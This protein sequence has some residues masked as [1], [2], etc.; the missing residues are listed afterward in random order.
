MEGGSQ[1][2]AGSPGIPRARPHYRHFAA[3]LRDYQRAEAGV[4]IG[5]RSRPRKAIFVRAHKKQHLSPLF[6]VEIC[7]MRTNFRLRGGLIDNRRSRGHLAAEGCGVVVRGGRRLL[8]APRPEADARRQ[9]GDSNAAGHTGHYSCAPAGSPW[10]G[11][12]FTRPTQS[13][14]IHFGG[15]PQSAGC[16]WTSA[17]TQPSTRANNSELRIGLEMWPSIP[18]AQQRSASPFMA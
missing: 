3:V 8:A 1:P 12:W 17:G 13:Q 14:G 5:C 9:A 16:F 2:G 11:R 7:A 18:A 15:G 4:G 10:R 6:P